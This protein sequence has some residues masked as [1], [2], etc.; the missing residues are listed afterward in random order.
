MNLEKHSLPE[1][2]SKAGEEYFRVLG[3]LNETALNL[4]DDDLEQARIHSTKL[5]NSIDYL[6]D[7]SNKKYNKDEWDAT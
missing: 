4:L 3:L 6:V 5:L 2:A 7:M 1:E